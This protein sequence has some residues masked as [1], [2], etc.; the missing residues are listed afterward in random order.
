[1]SKRIFQILKQ[2]VIIFFPRWGII[3]DDA[4]LAHRVPIYIVG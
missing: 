3:P 2:F 4:S 1:M